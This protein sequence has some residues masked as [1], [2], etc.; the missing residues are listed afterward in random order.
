MLLHSVDAQ[1]VTY[2]RPGERASHISRAHPTNG[3]YCMFIP[4]LPLL[5]FFPVDF[6]VSKLDVFRFMV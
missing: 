5:L 4:V 3:S 1:T 6:D 2:L